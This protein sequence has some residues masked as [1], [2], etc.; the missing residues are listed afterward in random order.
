MQDLNYTADNKKTRLFLKNSRLSRYDEIIIRSK[1]KTVTCDVIDA[2]NMRPQGRRPF[3]SL[4]QLHKL[5][6][7]GV[8]AAI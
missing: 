2:I 8:I 4:Y 7:I 5:S 1:K 3:S 6:S